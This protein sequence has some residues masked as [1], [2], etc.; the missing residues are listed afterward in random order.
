MLKHSSHQNPSS[1]HSSR[2]HTDRVREKTPAAPKTA[3]P[4][5]GSDPD[6]GIISDALDDDSVIE[7]SEEEVVFLHWRLLKE[8]RVLRNPETPLEEKLDTL[9]WIF[10]DR[11]KESRPFSFVSCLMVVGCSPLSPTPYFGL[12]DAEA[13]RDAIRCDVTAWLNA[14]LARYPNWVR[15]AF[16]SNPGWIEN[17]LSKNPQW[18]NEQIK[19]HTAE[20]DLFA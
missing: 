13:I 7:W 12:V 19:R 4:G 16:V 9:R 6:F 18:I 8:V 17:R 1:G 3:L 11:D 14:T 15:D 10:T 2:T 5:A 20:G